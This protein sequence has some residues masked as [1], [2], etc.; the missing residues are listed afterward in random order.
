M[1]NQ[2]DKLSVF[3]CA[4]SVSHYLPCSLNIR[5]V[6]GISGIILELFGIIWNIS[7]NIWNIHG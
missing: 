7:P 2:V 4:L 6:N 5:N 3:G 1:R